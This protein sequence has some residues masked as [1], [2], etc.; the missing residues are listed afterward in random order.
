MMEMNILYSIM[1]NYISLLPQ[2]HII[3]GTLTS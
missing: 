1:Y 3:L 2:Y